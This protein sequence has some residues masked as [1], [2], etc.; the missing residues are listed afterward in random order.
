MNLSERKG[1]EERV[2]RRNKFKYYEL[3]QSSKIIHKLFL[4]R[5][6]I[7]A[8]PLKNRYQHASSQTYQFHVFRTWELSVKGENG[9]G[10]SYFYCW[11]DFVGEQFFNSRDLWMLTDLYFMLCIEWSTAVPDI[12]IAK[13]RNPLPHHLSSGAL[14][15]YLT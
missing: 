5:M 4:N 7:I 14:I 9:S 13:Y 6:A 10:S 2:L 11:Y 8:F 12:V 1:V 3:N 15:H